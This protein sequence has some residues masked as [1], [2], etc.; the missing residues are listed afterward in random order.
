MWLDRRNHNFGLFQG[1][2]S[3]AYLGALFCTQDV[4][5]IPWDGEGIFLYSGC[6]THPLGWGD[7]SPGNIDWLNKYDRYGKINVASSNLSIFVTMLRS[8]LPEMSSQPSFW[9]QK[10]TEMGTKGSGN[11]LI[12]TVQH[13]RIWKHHILWLRTFLVRFGM[14]LSCCGVVFKLFGPAK[15]LRGGWDP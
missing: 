10:L 5:H 3:R 12:R 6:E 11:T 1:D 9:Y 13:F 15:C 8:K 14:K 7:V 4:R 2:I